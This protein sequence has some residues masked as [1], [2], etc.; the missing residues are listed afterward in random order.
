MG[1]MPTR[2]REVDAYI[3]AAPTF[4]RPLLER[5]R[6]AF[7]VG[8]PDLVER[9]KWGV[10]SFEHHGILGGMAAFQEH[11][12]F[13]FWKARLMEDPAG[14]FA[15]GARASPMSVRVRSAKDLPSKR[16]LV[17]YVRQAARLNEAGVKEPRL[18]RP[19][20]AIGLRV[21]SDLKAALAGDARARRTFEGF[22]PSARRDY[23]EWITEAKRAETRARRLATAIEWLAEGKR[24]NWK[25]ER[26]R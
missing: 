19:R 25:Y 2:S 26:R 18:A 1:S 21:P 8:C 7:H 9:I 20:G 13:G 5:L 14:L 10:P 6:A 22:P 15:S 4:A 23:V 17:A 11:V 3:A 12:S 24:R 16:V